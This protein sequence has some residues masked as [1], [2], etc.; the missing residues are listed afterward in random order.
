[1]SALCEG[2]VELHRILLDL[3]FVTFDTKVVHG[4]HVA[5]CV[6]RLVLCGDHDN[7]VR[8]DSLRMALRTCSSR[9]PVLNCV[10]VSMTL[11]AGLIA[12][13]PGYV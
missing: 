11:S 13:D 12:A 5:D 3:S 7:R 10:V 4:I 1:M 2:A 8:Y 9:G 6:P